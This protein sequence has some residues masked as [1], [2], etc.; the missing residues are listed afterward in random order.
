MADNRTCEN[1]SES[2]INNKSPDT[3]SDHVTDNSLACNYSADI[4]NGIMEEEHMHDAHT[5]DDTVTTSIRP[6]GEKKEEN[7]TA[8]VKNSTSLICQRCSSVVLLPR[9]ATF[10]QKQIFL[11]F[12]RKKSDQ[13]KT[14]EAS[15]DDGET[16]N[17][18]WLVNDMFTFENVGFSNTVG[19]VKYLICADCEIGPIGWHDV[20]VKNEFYIAQSRVEQRN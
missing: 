1:I 13:S 20:N 3:A 19:T 7:E 15:A 12:M 17:E 8:E 2:S 14:A 18:H 16:L 5:T 6:E 11:P 9:T 4:G 10:R